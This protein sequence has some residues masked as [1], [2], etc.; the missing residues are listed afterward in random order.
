MSVSGAFAPTGNSI[1]FTAN[2]AAPTAVQCSSNSGS[3]QYEIVN[4]GNVTVFMG[5]GATAALAGTNAVIPGA[6]SAPGIALLP[7]TDK[8]L[9]FNAN[10]FFTGITVSGAAN[11][12]VSPGDGL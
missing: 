12:Y 10:A 2:A 6:N 4:A 1:V 7:G 3:T 11:V 5:Q 8:V 9:T